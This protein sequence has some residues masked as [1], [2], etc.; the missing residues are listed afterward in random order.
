MVLTAIPKHFEIEPEI[1]EQLSAHPGHQRCVEGNGEV[2]LILHDVPEPLVPTRKTCYFW[3]RYDGRWAQ[4]AGAGLSDILWRIVCA[5][6]G[7]RDAE[8][9]LG[10][11]ARSGKVVLGLALDRVADHYRIR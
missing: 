5:G 2:L 8:S 10:W 7:M 9:A 1:R 6:E 4:S 3:K 11:P